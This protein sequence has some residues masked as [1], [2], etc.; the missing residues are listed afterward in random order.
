MELDVEVW[1][2]SDR[3]GTVPV[4]IDEQSGELLRVNRELLEIIEP[5]AE[6][7]TTES[8]WLTREQFGRFGIELS[9]DVNRVRLN[10]EIPPQLR[11][12]RE[13][14][15]ASA[16]DSRSATVEPATV[17]GGLNMGA[18]T[19]LQRR[20]EREGPTPELT[21]RL[22]PFLNIRDW[23]LEAEARV[24]TSQPEAFEIERYRLVHDFPDSAIRAQAGTLTYPTI[25]DQGRRSLVGL[26]V[27][28]RFELHPEVDRE[29]NTVEFFLEEAGDVTV[30]MNDR[31]IFSDELA[32]GPHRLSG[33]RLSDGRNRLRVES[34]GE[35]RQYAVPHESGVLPVG[36][37]DFAA[38]AGVPEDDPDFPLAVPAFGGFLRYGIGSEWSGGFYTHLDEGTQ[39]AG[40]ESVNAASWGAIESTLSGSRSDVSEISGQHGVRYGVAGSLLYRFMVPASAKPT[41]TLSLGGRSRYFST[42]AYPTSTQRYVADSAASVSVPV[43]EQAHL[44]AGVQS[45]FGFDSDDTALSTRLSGAVDLTRNARLRA[46]IR[47]DGIGTENVGFGGS[48]SF[49]VRP[50]SRDHSVRFQQSTQRMRTSVTVS[51]DG[52][53]GEGDLRWDTTSE[54]QP[55]ND[56]PFLVDGNLRYQGLRGNASVRS[57]VELASTQLTPFYLLEASFDSALLFAGSKF[58]VGPPAQSGYV[59]VDKHSSMGETTVGIRQGDGWHARSGWLGPAASTGYSAYRYS[60]LTLS[61]EE[62]P[63]NVGLGRTSHMLMPRYR[64]G[65]SLTVGVG[66]VVHVRGRALD[67]EGNPVTL[68]AG[69]A[70]PTEE[71]NEARSAIRFFT[72]ESGLFEIY[73][74]KPGAWELELS[75]G[76]TKTIEI[77]ADA[78]GVYE[79]GDIAVEVRNESEN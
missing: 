2:G 77:P 64:S 25:G 48:V 31:Q 23:V 52:N 1:L 14:T 41:I 28:R 8:A 69:I 4:V 17:S 36:T 55:P 21:L 65:Y 9:F 3:L 12:T 37:V 53:L 75:G 35:E 29:R 63:E 70:R 40:L 78:R 57:E 79:L 16:T 30:Y 6:T 62:V 72:D 19:A 27:E 10:V 61:A 33:V 76:R 13:H 7:P 15:V 42:S 5:I 47:L 56:R 59:L 58:A 34:D 26:A 20:S 49:Y 11:R 66:P 44:G 39:M 43:G 54:V 18:R 73:E 50:S 71:G 24:G 51:G 22:E 67:A 38:A 32:P 46:G 45:K 74:L 68:V 60:D